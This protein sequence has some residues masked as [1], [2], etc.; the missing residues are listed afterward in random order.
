MAPK[1]PDKRPKKPDV[2]IKPREKEMKPAYPMWP[3]R[4][5]SKVPCY[6]LLM[7]IT[8][9]GAKQLDR[10]DEHYEWLF[11]TVENLG[12]ELLCYAPTLGPYDIVAMVELPDDECA[13]DLSAQL[14]MH[15]WVSTVTMRAFSL[16]IL[17]TDSH[18]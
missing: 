11:A 5:D 14:A 7:N 10:L 8:Q 12:G 1:K 17:I 18:H 2:P 6:V 13:F 9:V 15:G 3:G 16:E 4:R